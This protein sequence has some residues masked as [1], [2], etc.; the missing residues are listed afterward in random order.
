MSDKSP[1][2]SMSKKPG[3]SLK[4]KRAEKRA[5]TDQTPTDGILHSKKH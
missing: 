1:R 5:K 2:Q 4:E 3:K